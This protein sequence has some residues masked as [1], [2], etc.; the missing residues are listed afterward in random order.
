MVFFRDL[1][2]NSW[3]DCQSRLRVAPTLLV[4]EPTCSEPDIQLSLVYVCCALLVHMFG[5]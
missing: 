3:V 5:P 4:V 2:V 1:A